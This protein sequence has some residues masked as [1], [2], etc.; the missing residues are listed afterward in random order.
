MGVSYYVA[1]KKD[2][3][4]EKILILFLLLSNGFLVLFRKYKLDP[5]EN[6]RSIAKLRGAAEICKHV[7]STMQSAHCFAESLVD[8]VDLSS[9]VSRARFE[10]ILSPLLPR[11]LEPVS[12]AI[13]SAGITPKEIKKVCI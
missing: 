11:L 5:M 4:F 3:K 10:S 8:G 13:E 12:K 1:V 6:R 2:Y 9:N 7:L